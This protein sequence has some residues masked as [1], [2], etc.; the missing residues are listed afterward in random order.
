[1]ISDLITVNFTRIEKVDNKSNR[2][3][4]NTC[5]DKASSKGARI[6]GRD[7]NLPNHLAHGCSDASPNVQR[8]ARTFILGKTRVSECH[9]NRTSAVIGCSA[10]AL[11]QVVPIGKRKKHSD[12]LD[13]YVDY[14]PTDK[15]KSQANSCLL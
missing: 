2:W 13:G 6:Q 11:D 3:K 7:N 10:R 12:S 8:E 15:Q 9:E 1:P 4:C 5:G 14:P